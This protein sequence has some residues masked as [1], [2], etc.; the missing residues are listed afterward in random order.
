MTFKDIFNVGDVVKSYDFNPA[1]CD[2][3][4]VAQ[5]LEA[6]PSAYTVKVIKSVSDSAK[7]DALRKGVELT[8]PYEMMVDFLTRITLVADKETYELISSEV[9]EAA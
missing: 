3:Y 1:I 5:I 9:P 4:I 6:G 8:V 7:F 2:S